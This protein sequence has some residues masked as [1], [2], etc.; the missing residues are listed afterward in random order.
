MEKREQGGDSG[1]RG[2]G[3]PGPRD[4]AIDFSGYT[5]SQLHDLRYTLDG[6]RFPDNFR[7]LLIEINRRSTSAMAAD[8]EISAFPG[9]FTRR[10]GLRGWIEAVANRSPVYG[11]GSIEITRGN[12]ALNGWQR[13]WLGAPFQTQVTFPKDAVRNVMREDCSVRFELKRSHRPVKRLAFRAESAG[14]AAQVEGQLPTVATPGFERRSTEI[15]DFNVRLS[16][17]ARPL[18]ITPAILTANVLVFV[19]M[20][21]ATRRITGFTPPEILNWGANL[22]PLTVNGQWWRL[23]T[24]TFVH[25]SLAHLLLNMW[26]LWNIGRLCE[27]IFGR[28]TFSFLYFASGLV[29]SLSSIVWNPDLSSAGASGAI[30]GILGA[31]IAFYLNPLNRVPAMIARRHWVSTCAFA[32]FNLINGALHPGIDNAAHVGG[33]LAGFALGWILARPLEIEGR[34]PLSTKQRALALSLLVAAT[35]AAILQVKGIGSELTAPEQ[36]YRSHTA[37]VRGEADN[38]RLW[39]ELAAKAA[40]GTISDSELAGRFEHDIVPFWRA[41]HVQLDEENK[42][43]KDPLRSYALL[44]ADFVRIRHEWAQELVQAL[45]QGDSAGM[46]AAAELMLKST[47]AQARLER[48]EIRARMDHRPRALANNPAVA[49]LRRL[50]IGYHRACIEPPLIY[51]RIPTPSDNTEDGP[52]ARHAIGCRAQQ[53][54]MSED[55]RELDSLMNRYAGTLADLPDG[56]SRYEG[57]V[58]GLNDL[59]TG[60]G[61]DALQLL[62]RTSDWR[63]SVK[64]STRSD[65]VEAMI[66]ETSAWSVRGTGDAKSVSAQQWA[67]FSYRT[68]MAAAALAD[69][70]ASARSDPLWYQLSLNIGLDQGLDADHLRSIFDEGNARFP[71]YRPLERRMMRI[72][73]PRWLGSYEKEDDFISAVYPKAVPDRGFERYAELYSEYS[74]LEGDDVDL[75]SDTDASWSNMRSGYAGLMKRYPGSDFVLNRFANLACRAGDADEYLALRDSL[76]RRYSS[77]A[78]SDKYSV[79]ACNQQFLKSTPA[80]AATTIS[81]RSGHIRALGGLQLGETAQ[82]VL[83]AKG[84]PIFRQQKSWTFNTVDSAHNGVVTATFSAAPDDPEAKVVAV[85]FIG[86]EKSAPP[87]LPYLNGLSEDDLRDEFGYLVAMGS[88]T[89][90]TTTLQYKNG[91]Y[92]Q[93][94][95][96]KVFRYGI[97]AVNSSH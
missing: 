4:G 17:I 38:L 96:G 20:C 31:F 89:T 36:Y 76:V 71:Q 74:D 16:A 48:V 56:S 82:Q 18:I 69:T 50:L 43:V 46:A 78:W 21:V 2:S 90:D 84:A 23:L 19:V 63:R 44:V 95:N 51:G 88:P 9:R 5:D 55:Y 65:V 45:R 12:L 15:R 35:A 97:Y 75:F 1:Q 94:R 26:A 91:V 10:D 39:N 8:P 86:D 13:T 14:T 68:Q 53:L 25:L 59:F 28:L 93:T 62:G 72:L 24:A 29:A 37:L 60:G 6:E 42:A 30:F 3:E 22:G 11:T 61:L 47:A 52:A 58:G 87:E 77:V 7:N 33:L 32:A 57:L 54:F 49:A 80:R 83:T 81:R 79:E 85:E 41:A 40:A 70:A 34:R 27:R 64:N 92:A 73:M 66:F 67:L